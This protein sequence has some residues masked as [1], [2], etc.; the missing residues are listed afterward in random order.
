MQADPWLELRRLRANVPDGVS[1]G[2]VVEL[3][4][5]LAH[6]ESYH[7]AAATAGPETSAVSLYYCLVQLGK[8]A[9]AI[10]DVE[11]SRSH[12]LEVITPATALTEPDE[13]DP[14]AGLADDPV[15]IE[16]GAA[17]EHDPDHDDE[18]S[19]EARVLPDLREW[20]VRDSR[21]KKLRPTGSHFATVE[22]ATRGPSIDRFETSIG[23][24]ID[25]NPDLID[26]FRNRPTGR[27]IKIRPVDL[28]AHLPYDKKLPKLAYDTE[29][30]V[31][32]QIEYAEDHPKVMRDYPI[33]R[34]GAVSLWVSGN[35]ESLDDG[36]YE[37]GFGVAWVLRDVSGRRAGPELLH[38]WTTPGLYASV[39]QSEYVVSP[40]G[41][42]GE[43][44]TR[45]GWWWPLLYALGHVTRYEPVAWS[46]AI[47][48]DGDS[49]AA[50]LREL[51][52]RAWRLIPQ[53]GLWAMRQARETHD[54]LPPTFDSAA[55]LVIDEAE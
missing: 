55:T 23:E 35:G 31:A 29:V 52:D 49:S 46:R 15:E 11:A 21:K 33:T 45:L 41:P 22:L 12:G 34:N 9:A 10:A 5:A 6:A 53:M 28:E 1:S 14:V 20:M 24:L 2:R 54:D 51:L 30:R 16:A 3:Q 4:S 27:P 7:R 32:R 19:G 25:G 40:K 26:L 39:Y 36:W 48:L 38:S 37:R 43:R 13:T 47:D 18:D 44:W 8:A 17:R 42:L 50:D